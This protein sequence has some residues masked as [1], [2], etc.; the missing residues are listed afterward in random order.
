MGFIRK[1]ESEARMGEKLEEREF[2]KVLG[3]MHLN[4]MPLTGY[5]P[6]HFRIS[7][8]GDVA[9]INTIGIRIGKNKMN[10]KNV[11][12]YRRTN[13]PDPFIDKAAKIPSVPKWRNY[14]VQYE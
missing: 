2:K 4:D 9:C 10:H 8:N 1:K 14:N 7:H 12:L 13:T 11:D 5:T 3:R 6:L